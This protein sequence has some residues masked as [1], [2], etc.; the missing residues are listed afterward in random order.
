MSLCIPDQEFPMS[1][2]TAFRQLL[3]MFT[4]LFTAGEKLGKTLD[5][6]ATVAEETSAG[7]V[8]NTRAQRAHDAIAFKRQLK[9]TSKEA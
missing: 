1:F 3:A 7:Y 4:V 9:L 5:N 8:D 2:G 6:L